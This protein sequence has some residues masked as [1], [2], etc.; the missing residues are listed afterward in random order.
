VSKGIAFFDFDGTITRKDTMLEL[1]KYARGPIG[2][3]SGMLLLSPWLIAMKLKLISRTQAK[4][5]FLTRF[6]GNTPEKEFGELCNKFTAEII[7]SLIRPAALIAIKKHQEQQTEVV[8]VSASASHW[9]A[10]WCNDCQVKLIATELEII[11]NKVTGKLKN[12]NCHGKEKVR[13]IKEAFTLADYS[14][15]YCYGD[16][17]GDKP[18][19][20]LATFAFYK[21]FE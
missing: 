8:I 9:I 1:A 15:V 10:A 7:P 18:M 6:F 2:F 19:L 4:E 11:N 14:A 12:S 16:T 13:R 3:Y 17:K 21:P 20:E 5:K